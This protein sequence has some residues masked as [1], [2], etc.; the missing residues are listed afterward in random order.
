MVSQITFSTKTPIFGAQTPQTKE[1][2][3]FLFFGV[4]M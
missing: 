1:D 4:P 2:P 3:R